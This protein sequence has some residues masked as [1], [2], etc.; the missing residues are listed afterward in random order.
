MPTQSTTTTV[1]AVLADVADMLTGVVG[2]DVS[3]LG[4]LGM[5]TS[6]NDDLCL[7]SIQ[8]VVLAEALHDRYGDQ[9]DFVAWLASMDLD[10]IID[11][12]VG[13]LVEFIVASLE[14]GDHG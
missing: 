3:L 1:E 11:L 13:Q 12:N 2:A 6:F 4:P 10:A 14:G 7:E 5:D 8:F 9:V